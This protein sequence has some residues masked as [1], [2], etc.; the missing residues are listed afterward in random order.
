MSGAT[1]LHLRAQVAA[2][3]ETRT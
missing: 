1:G 2:V 3:R